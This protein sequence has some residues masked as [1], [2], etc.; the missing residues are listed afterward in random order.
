MLMDRRHEKE[1]IEGGIPS[2]YEGVST[3]IMISLVPIVQYGYASL[4]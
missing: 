1:R 4:M 3:L 2:V